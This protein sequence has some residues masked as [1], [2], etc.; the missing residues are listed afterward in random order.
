MVLARAADPATGLPRWAVA[1]APRRRDAVLT[2]VRDLLGAVQTG[3]TPDLGDPLLADLDPAALVP[4]DLD[5]AA[6]VPTGESAGAHATGWAAVA[7]AL[8][9]AGR[10]VLTAPI[11]APDLAAGRLHTTR[12]L[13]TTPGAR[14]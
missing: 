6:L 12:V 11:H 9:A 2:A 10:D 3:G 13:L 1:A 14:P 7:A 8:R 5:P 4:T